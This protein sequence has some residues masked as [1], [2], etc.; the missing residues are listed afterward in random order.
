MLREK[1][2]EKGQT[3]YEI[4]KEIS[5]SRST[6]ENRLNRF[7][8]ETRPR[9][10]SL[11]KRQ[12]RYGEKVVRG[13]KVDHLAEVR[14]IKSILQMRETGL[15][16]RQIAKVLDELKVLTKQKGKGWHPEMISRIL[17]HYKERK[18]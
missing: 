3:V 8:I 11:H 13:E 1:Y 17:K 10:G 7:G 6:V 14:V 2:S 4:A 16:L 18:K 5:C 15:S 9:K 12:P